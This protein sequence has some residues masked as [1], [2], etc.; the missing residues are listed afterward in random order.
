MCR[1]LSLDIKL[2]FRCP[3]DRAMRA[4]TFQ[5]S[6]CCAVMGSTLSRATPRRKP[7]S[8][9]AK[10]AARFWNRARTGRRWIRIRQTL[11]DV[12]SNS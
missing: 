12:T 7:I 6:P 8:P 5:A 10:P 4:V 3:V 9:A 2:D 1:F 11:A